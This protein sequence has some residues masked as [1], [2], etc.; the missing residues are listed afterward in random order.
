[1]FTSCV[2]SLLVARIH[3]MIIPHCQMKDS[4]QN[5]VHSKLV[6]FLRQKLM[7]SFKAAL[8]QEIV[9]LEQDV[10]KAK[11]AENK[12]IVGFISDSLSALLS[13]DCLPFTS[14]QITPIYCTSLINES[15]LPT[16]TTSIACNHND[17]RLSSC[18]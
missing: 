9:Q 6:L 5:S 10:G 12:T 14:R 8:L 1:M 4:W 7:D 16:C 11:E 13:L 17:N 18:N 3:L 2:N 15:R